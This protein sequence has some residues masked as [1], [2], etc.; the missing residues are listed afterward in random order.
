VSTSSDLPTGPVIVWTLAVLGILAHAFI[1]RR[2]QASR[3]NDET[4]STIP[5]ARHEAK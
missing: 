4:A 5:S 1:A 3:S 2:A